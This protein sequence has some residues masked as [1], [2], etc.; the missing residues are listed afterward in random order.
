M[1]KGETSGGVSGATVVGMGMLPG[2]DEEAVEAAEGGKEE[3]LRKQG[4]TQVGAAGHGGD[5]DG[6]AEE[7]ANSDLLGQTMGFLPRRGA[8]YGVDEDEVA[9]EETSEDEVKM[10]SGDFEVRKEDGQGDR[11]QEDSDKEGGAVAVVKVVASFEVF[12]RDGVD[13]MGVHEAGVHQTIGGVEHPDGY[14]HGQDGS[15]WK[16]DVLGARDEP[17]PE[18]SDG[19]CV[20]REQ[21]P[22][23]DRRMGWLRFNGSAMLVLRVLDW[24]RSGHVFILGQ[25]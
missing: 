4:E 18:C 17:G 7:D 23:G 14:G 20:E 25:R 8:W 9:G 6:G 3:R 19:R 5:K 2:V 11:G 10:Q 12:R 15:D 22:E 24:S 16:M 21:M 13:Q 1:A